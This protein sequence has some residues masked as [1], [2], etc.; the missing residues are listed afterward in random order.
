MSEKSLIPVFTGADYKGWAFKV[1]FGLADRE[2]HDVV[3]DWDGIP[4]QSRPAVSEPLT[5]AEKEA[6]RANDDDVN[7]AII[8]RTNLIA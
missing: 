6:L 2:S 4:K 7:R 5:Q 8:S 1:K 3:M